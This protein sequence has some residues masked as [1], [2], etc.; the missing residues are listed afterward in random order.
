LDDR[1]WRAEFDRVA[2]PHLDAA[3]NL[4]RWLTRH[5]QDAE[6]VVQ[7]AFLRA[8]RFFRSFHGESA[9]AWLLQIVRNTCSTWLARNRFV[10]PRG[11]SPQNLD[12][13]Q[14]PE[15][16]PETRMERVEDQRLL[17]QAIADLPIDFREVIVLREVEGLSY[18]EI[19]RIAEIPPGTVMSR[20]ARARERLREILDRNVEGEGSHG[21]P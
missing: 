1:D 12:E 14:A 16:N 7:E 9:R 10:P 4:A 8:Y 21:M 3:Y 5:E 20:L 13:M 17:T 2:L 19:A 6:D 15:L 18:K 11:N